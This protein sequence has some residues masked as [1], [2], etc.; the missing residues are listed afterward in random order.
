MRDWLLLDL[1]LFLRLLFSFCFCR[2][3]SSYFRFSLRIEIFESCLNSLFFRFR[4]SCSSLWSF[5]SLCLS[6]SCESFSSTISSLSFYSEFSSCISLIRICF[7]HSMAAEYLLTSFS[8]SLLLSWIISWP[9][10]Y[11]ASMNLQLSWSASSSNLSSFH[12]TFS[13]RSAPVVTYRA[14][15]AFISLHSLTAS[16]RE[17]KDE[18]QIPHAPVWVS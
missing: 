12:L 16:E 11:L 4:Y 9:S 15:L 8:S 7:Q 17:S 10:L 6:I 2:F 1:V 13:F 3:S 18:A 5:N 14:R